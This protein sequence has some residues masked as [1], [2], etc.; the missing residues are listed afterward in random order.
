MAIGLETRRQDSAAVQKGLQGWDSA[1]LGSRREQ[2]PEV[3][4]SC[5][6]LVVMVGSLV[7]GLALCL[8]AH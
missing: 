3:V 1:S 8:G 7:V 4:A 6:P 2:W 5:S